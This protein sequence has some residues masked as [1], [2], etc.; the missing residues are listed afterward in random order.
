MASLGSLVVRLGLDAAEFTSGLTKS[1]RAA[2]QFAQ[3]I[4]RGIATAAK[5]ATIAL[6][7]LTT[8]AVA[9]FAAINELAQQAAHF[10][11]LEEITGANAEALASF[12]VSAQ[13]AGVSADSVADAMVKLTKNMTGVDDE[14]KAAGAA[15]TALG[16]SIKDFKALDP[17][18]QME[19]VAKALAGFQDGAAKTAVALAL[20]GKTGAQLLPFLKE[21]SEGSG[22]VVIINQKLIDQADAYADAQAKARAEL[23]LYAQVA[24]SQTLPAITTLTGATK[25]FVAELIGVDTQG[26]KL[27]DSNAITDFANNAVQALGFIVSAG[28]GLG[29]VFQIVGETI[30]AGAAQAAAV[31][32]GNLRGAIS[33]GRDWQEQVD[34]ILQKQL[35]STQLAQR[36]KTQQDTDARRAIE[37]RGFKPPGRVLNFAGAVTGNTDDPARKI[38]DGEIKA[39]EASITRERE[40]L[41]ARQDFLRDYYQDGRLSLTQYYDEIQAARDINLQRTFAALN[42]EIALAEA[43]KARAAKLSEKEGFQNQA[44]AAREKQ[45]TLTLQAQFA[46]ESLARE[47]ARATERYGF[48]LDELNAKMKELAGNTAAAAAIRFDNQNAVFNRGLQSSGNTAALAQQEAIKAATVA[49]AALNDRNREFQLVLNGVGLAQDRV[50]LAAQTGAI[51][52]FEALTKTS[53][54]AA[55]QI[56]KLTAIADAMQAIASQARDLNADGSI[57]IVKL[58]QL[59]KVEELRL[60]IERLRAQTDL[61]KDKF[62]NLGASALSDAIQQAINGTGTLAERL[63]NA[64]LGFG[65]SLS[66]SITKVIA[67]NL[68]QKAFGKGGIFEGFGSILGGLFGGGGKEA[69]GAALAGSATALTG[70]ATLLTTAGT[71][72]TTAGASLTAAAAAMAASSATDT[73]S[74]IFG[75]FSGGGFGEHFASGGVSRGGLAWVGENGPEPVILPR[76][77]RVVAN[78]QARE[79]GGPTIVQNINIPAGANT[80]SLR[81]EAK[82]AFA[83]GA[84]QARRG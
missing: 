37:D 39:L 35:F 62:N 28:Q 64:A 11:D 23:N 57:N 55:A 17:A 30:A 61:L 7:S 5:A 12:S 19:A 36:I 8:A 31:A 9:G 2:Q 77:A 33:I 24:A 6:A 49:Q 63:K 59:Q 68:A 10:K 54:A 18:S 3:R 20:F 42:K 25:D 27:R 69:G 83:M 14:S 44:D 67:D 1:E 65:K 58:E 34:R 43:A 71:V 80:A 26:K 52:E 21:L 53:A 79:L 75:G 40:I 22:R 74:S 16:L 81:Q 66:E 47:R 32:S 41:S 29:R 73:I 45:T 78:H 15:L 4:D 38:L 56:P 72:L 48:E 84:R 50:A 13:V 46:E 76:G 70:S 60:G 82:R 51:N